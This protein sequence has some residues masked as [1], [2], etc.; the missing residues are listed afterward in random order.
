MI[1]ESG[2][3]STG[4]RMFSLQ[5]LQAMTK[6]WTPVAGLWNIDAV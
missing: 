3:V 5:P 2:M 4:A 6:G 1:Q